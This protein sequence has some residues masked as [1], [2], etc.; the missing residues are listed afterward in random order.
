[1]NFV[2]DSVLT[3]RY[4]SLVNLLADKLLFPEFK[5]PHLDAPKIGGPI[6]DW[7]DHAFKFEQTRGELKALRAKVMKPGACQWAAHYVLEE[8]Q[9]R[10]SGRS[11]S[12]A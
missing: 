8:V 9:R 7:L 1:M 12:A 11:Q 10:R 6:V 3:C 5:G 4:F 2:A